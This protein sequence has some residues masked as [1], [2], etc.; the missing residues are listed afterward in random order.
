MNGTIQVITVKD[1]DHENIVSL[2]PDQ[3]FKVMDITNSNISKDISNDGEFIDL[4]KLAK[5][6][7]ITISKTE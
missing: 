2:I 3:E 7:M 1:Q 4:E 5:V 6:K